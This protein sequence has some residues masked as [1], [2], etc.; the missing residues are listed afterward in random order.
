MPRRAVVT[1]ELLLLNGFELRQG[2]ASVDLPTPA[3]RVLA[4]LALH[5]RPLS[6]SFV[7]G[8]LWP[9]TTEAKAAGNLRTSLWRL[10]KSSPGVI[11]A[12]SMDLRLRPGVRVDVHEM[13]ATARRLISRDPL[14]D[15]AQVDPDILAADLL[16]GWW[17]TWVVFE[18]ERLR[19]TSLHG[20]E[21]LSELLLDDG[22]WA[23]A[24]IAAAAAVTAEPLRESA[25]RLLIR[26]HLAA[27]NRGEATRQ[28]QRYEAILLEELGV[29]PAEDLKLLMGRALTVPRN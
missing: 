13:C 17:D 11:Q 20:L 4:F 14:L 9:E 2:G 5:E 27:G 12:T 15:I 26:V 24:A 28:Y 16:P 1:A 3:K 25:H 18:R 21:A 29:E 8:S 10:R 19:Q 23:K 22:R 7:S 6:R